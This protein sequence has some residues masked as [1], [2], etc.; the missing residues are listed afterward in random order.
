MSTKFSLAREVTVAKKLLRKYPSSFRWVRRKNLCTH[1]A[2]GHPGPRLYHPRKSPRVNHTAC[3]GCTAWKVLLHRYKHIVASLDRSGRRAPHDCPSAAV[4][5]FQGGFGES[6]H[7]GTQATLMKTT[8]S[9]AN[10]VSSTKKSGSSPQVGVAGKG[11]SLLTPVPMLNEARP[12][13]AVDHIQVYARLPK[14][15]ST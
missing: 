8:N 1:G 9:D 2:D 13:V 7:A 15:T 6:L 14:P 5:R 10:H 4:R 12:P 11:A 3:Q